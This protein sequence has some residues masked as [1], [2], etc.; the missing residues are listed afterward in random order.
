MSKTLYVIS[1]DDKGVGG[2]LCPPGHWNHEY[3]LLA[4]FNGR[5]KPAI[6]GFYTIEHAL[7]PQSQAS[8]QVQARVRAIMASSELVCSEL[9]L[10]SV[11]GYFR[12]CY[13]A[14]DGSRDVSRCR[15][16]STHSLPSQVHL[17]VVYVRQFFPDHSPREDLIA[18]P[19]RG[20]GVHACLN[21]GLQVQYEARADALVALTG[22]NRAICAQ[23]VRGRHIIKR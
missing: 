10:R 13:A 23:G 21:C 19:G 1:R 4:Y 18:D 9:W 16:D 5:R 6:D 11:Y 15:I 20:Y 7:D 12:N 3:V 8:E 17:A 22:D 14:E 2:F